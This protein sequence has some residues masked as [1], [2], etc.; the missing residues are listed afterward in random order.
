MSSLRRIAL[1]AVACLCAGPAATAGG[2]RD[3]NWGKIRE[4][5]RKGAFTATF[6]DKF[7]FR[8]PTGYRLVYDDKI[9]EFRELMG[10]VAG[11]DDVGIV[12]PEEGGWV[13]IV[14][15]PPDDPMKGQDPKQL[16]AEALMKWN[17]KV[18]EDARPKRSAVGLSGQ[19]V[20][21]WTHKPAY[22]ADGKKL[23]MGL[24]VTNEGERSGGRR[25][26]L[27]YKTVIYGPDGSFV[28]LQTE[29]AIGNWD[30]PLEETKKLA[31]EFSPV[32]A[33][34]TDTAEDPYYYPKIGGAGVVGVVL[35][36]VLAKLIGGRRTEVAPARQAARRFGNA[37]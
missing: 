37:R 16:N 23:T 10:E 18:Y 26:E 17:Q 30:K 32:G 15:F 8:V 20:T 36:I 1:A 13:A 2:P 19:R 25:D 35:V 29:T 5:S 4:Y 31:G 14:S 9:A 3:L 28:C 33:A 22:D 7:T 11:P 24:R 34:E 21:G 12:L 6:R 27:H